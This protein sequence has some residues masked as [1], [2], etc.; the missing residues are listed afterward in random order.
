LGAVQ[1]VILNYDERSI[2]TAGDYLDEL[3]GT[4]PLLEGKTPESLK[5]PVY[6]TSA[7]GAYSIH[8]VQAIKKIRGQDNSM[9]DDFIFACLDDYMLGLELWNSGFKVKALPIITAKHS[10]GTSFNRAGAL[11]AYLLARNMIILHEI[12][13]SR[14]RNLAKL[15][16]LRQLYGWFLWRILGLRI[17]Q[18]SK[19]LPALLSRA[20]VDGIRIGRTK[21]RLGETIDIYMA[22]ILRIG[23][24]TA[25]LG[26][27]TRQRLMDSSIRKELDKI[28]RT[29][30]Q[31]PCTRA[32]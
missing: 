18:G 28:A 2:D 26:I 14:Y 20:F 7:D 12:S 21:R 32:L 6:I 31:E 30:E 10:R 27:M 19:E 1:G 25:L 16:F 11:R 17:E 24:A 9:F 15:L 8:R 3:F 29:P 4:N 5:K 23:Y 22:P 13:N